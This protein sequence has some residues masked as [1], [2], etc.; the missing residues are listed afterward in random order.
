MVVV[1]VN[2]VL[3]NLILATLLELLSIYKTSYWRK[4]KRKKDERAYTNFSWHT[5]HRLQALLRKIFSR[6]LLRSLMPF[7]LST[8]YQIVSSPSPSPSS[9][10]SD[11]QNYLPHAWLSSSGTTV[12]WR[13]YTQFESLTPHR[14]GPTFP[15]GQVI[16]L[17][18]LSPDPPGWEMIGKGGGTPPPIRPQRKYTLDYRRWLVR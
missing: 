6:N 11:R 9:S 15:Q 2:L 17:F 5:P 1:V 16:L 18:L 10:S 7:F 8:Q 3:G 14:K 12:C 4:K 13:G